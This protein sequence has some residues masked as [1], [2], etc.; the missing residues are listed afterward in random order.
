MIESLIYK[1]G[2]H[3]FEDGRIEFETIAPMMET[4]HKEIILTKERAIRE[5][6]IALGWTPP[7]E[8]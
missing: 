1:M 5:G 2:S 3:V 8:V 7:P 6:L 4:I